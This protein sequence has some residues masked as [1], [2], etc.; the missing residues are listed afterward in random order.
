[1]WLYAVKKQTQE[2]IATKYECTKQAVGQRLDDIQKRIHSKFGERGRDLFTPKQ[3]VLEAK[4]PAPM[5][6]PGDFL[7][8]INCGGRWSVRGKWI[9]QTKCFI[10]EYINFAKCSKCFDNNGVSKCTRKE[11]N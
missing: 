2:K 3:S 11:V 7:Q 5:G 4:Y 8:H 9:S 10:P 1:M 6:Y